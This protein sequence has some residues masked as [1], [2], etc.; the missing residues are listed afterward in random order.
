MVGRTEGRGD[1]KDNR[2]AAQQ[3]EPGSRGHITQ[4]VPERTLMICVK[5][6]WPRVKSAS[7]KP[8]NHA[9]RSVC[10]TSLVIDR[11][12]LMGQM[13]TPGSVGE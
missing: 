3:R 7:I 4:K 10:A 11:C 13:R 2:L 9:S 8:S 12:G 6:R 5:R 1:E